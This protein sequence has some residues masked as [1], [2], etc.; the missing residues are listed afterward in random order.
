MKHLPH[1][2][3]L[4]QGENT[5]IIKTS[6]ETECLAEVLRNREQ[7]ANHGVAIIRL[8]LQSYVEL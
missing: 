2:E 5:L 4:L 7:R 3:E 1:F 8:L 6:S